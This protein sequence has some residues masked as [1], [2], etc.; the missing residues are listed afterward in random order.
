MSIKFDLVRLLRTSQR[1]MSCEELAAA[2]HRRLGYIRQVCGELHALKR[3]HIVAWIPPR[4]RG[5]HSPIF[6]IGPGEDAP[7]PPKLTDSE[8]MLRFRLN[9]PERVAASRKKCYVKK[10]ALKRMYSSLLMSE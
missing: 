3:I 6:A 2:L 9:S 7:L 8:R 4:S 5:R 1:D 10:A